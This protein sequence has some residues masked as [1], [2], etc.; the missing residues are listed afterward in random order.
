MN[1]P[2]VYNGLGVD[3]DVAARN[4]ERA[5]G[6]GDGVDRW[7]ASPILLPQSTRLVQKTGGS[8]KEA[9]CAR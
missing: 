4:W 1:E 6:M 7:S 8:V 5:G 2:S 9:A 3:D